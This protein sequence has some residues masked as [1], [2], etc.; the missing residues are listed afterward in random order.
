MSSDTLTFDEAIPRRPAIDDVG[1]GLKANA[2]TPPDPVRD[3]TAEDFNQLSKQAVA[4]GRV[5]PLATLFVT[6]AG[7]PAITAVL[8]PGSSI[9]A[10][11]FTVVDNGVGDTTIH[12]VVTKLPVRTGAPKVSQTDDVEIDRLRAFYTTASG[13]PAVRIKSNLTGVATDC[14]FVVDI[15]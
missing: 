11:D 2:A 12:W 3:A 1:G 15:M 7:T 4:H 8:A 10:T 13:N 6:N 14:S 9:D 5:I